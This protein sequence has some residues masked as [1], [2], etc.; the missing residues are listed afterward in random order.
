MVKSHFLFAVLAIAIVAGAS[1]TSAA[2]VPREAPAAGSVVAVRAGE[3]I[4]FVDTTSWRNVEVLQDV[5][6]GDVLRT[7]ALGQLAILFSDRTQVRVARNSTLLVKSIVPGGDTTLSLT[8]GSIFARAARGGTGVTVETPAAAAAIRGTDWAMTVD[9]DR[10]TLTVLEG[11]VQFSNPQGSLTLRQGEAAAATIGQ[12]PQRLIVVNSNDRE[13]MLL[14]LSLRDAFGL[15]PGTGSTGTRIRGERDRLRAKP[16]QTWSAEDRVAA[17]EVALAFEGLPAARQAA[18]AAEAQ[19]LG[20]AERAR[21]LAVKATIAGKEGRYG[22]AARLF[23]EAA[24]HLDANRRI[25]ARYQAY[26]ARALADPL[27]AEAPPAGGGDT[28]SGVVSEALVAAFLEDLDRALAVLQREEPRFGDDA[29][30]QTLIAQ[31]ALATAR[32]DL[33]KQSIDKALAADPG[34]LEAIATR[35][36]YRARVLSDLKGAQADL[37]LV[38][39]EAPGNVDFLN[40]YANVLDERGAPREA[41]AVF[42]QAIEADPGDLALRVNYAIFLLQHERIPEAKAQLDKAAAIA[43]A[44]SPVA[45]TRAIYLLQAGETEAAIDS[46]LTATTIDPGV[47]DALLSLAVSYFLAGEPELGHQA[48]DNADRLDPNNPVVSQYRAI[49]AIDEYQADD[50][51]RYARESVRRTRE[52]GG[53]YASVAATRESGTT[54]GEAFRFVGLESWSRYYSDLV[55]DPFLPGAFFDQWQSGGAAVFANDPADIFSGVDPFRGESGQS[56]LAQGLLLDPGAIAGPNLRPNLVRAP[57]FEVEAAP[58]YADKEGD[59][60]PLGDITVQG[61]ATEPF[62]VAA[63]I[64]GS[65]SQLPRSFAE[66]D[67]I[68][69]TGVAFFGAQP[70]P[71]DRLL[72]VATMSEGRGGLATR[73][74]PDSAFDRDVASSRS[75]LLGWSHTFGYRNVLNVAAYGSHA[76]EEGSQPRPNLPQPYTLTSRTA[77]DE[78]SASVS[79]AVGFGDVTVRYGGDWAHTETEASYYAALPGPPAADTLLVTRRQADLWRGYAD[80]LAQISPSLEIEA[81]LFATGLDVT[82]EAFRRTGG[83]TQSGSVTDDPF[84]LD[85]RIGIGWMPIEGQW[86]RAGYLGAGNGPLSFTLAPM[87]VVGLR[88]SEFETSLTDGHAHHTIARWDAEW[89]DHVFTSAEYRHQELDDL[90]IAVPGGADAISIDRATIDRLSLTADLKVP[91]GI[92]LFATFVRNWSEN[93]TPGAGFGNAVPFVPDTAG[94][95]G[96]TFV[97]PSRVKVTVRENYI[98]ERLGD[99]GGTPLDD[100]WTTDLAVSWESTNRRLYAELGITNLFDASFVAAPAQLDPATGLLLYPEVAAEGRV[101][102]AKMAVRF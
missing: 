92:G 20:P 45:T 53:D 73:E 85:P 28:Y 2:P 47:S 10:T 66:Q 25:F 18:E 42:R 50:A 69:G 11:V 102:T 30:Y 9:G 27:R 65:Y 37:A 88:E 24:P 76:E 40:E 3:E 59:R 6:A 81:A 91:G 5:K 51:V 94:R 31:L 4:D 74:L 101:I 13:Q 61:Y 44:S 48:I 16:G 86:L 54:V 26:F 49:I 33:A 89:T 79:H 58:G 21:L 80:I 70:L 67:E 87:G 62:P 98:G 99:L 55:F 75:G 12:A 68:S 52:R 1:R 83:G 19:P 72:A 23:E 82:D 84:R 41:E 60:G 22:E 100:A 38:A 8:R 32:W 39:R 36:E 96:I 97:H 95:V 93:E 15:L 29:T 90:S 46:A 43:P 35:G 71:Y 17:A 77:V 64:S 14:S 63:V 7:N 78:T 57:F 56:S 34:S